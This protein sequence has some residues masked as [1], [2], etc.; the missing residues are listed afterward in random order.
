MT[1]GEFA[2][3][4]L[5]EYAVI[6]DGQRGA[7]I[8]PRG[9]I[10][11]L[12]MPQWHGDAVFA[13]L[14]GGAGCYAVT[15]TDRHVWGG[16]YQPGTLIWN[17]RW[18]TSDGVVEC[19]E[20]LAYPGR[21]G[22]AVLLRR[23]TAVDGDARMRV[24]L[25]PR[26]DYGK[27]PSDR[28]R[29]ESGEWLGVAG[30]TPWGWSGAPD[31]RPDADGRLVAELTV[32]AG[33]RHDLV[34]AIGTDEPLPA[35]ATCWPETE[36]A[37]RAAVGDLDIVAADDARHSLAV[38]RGL[39]ST[40]GGMV[41]AMTTSM[42][43]RFEAGRNYDYRYVWIRDQAMAGQAAAAAGAY[44]M[45]DDTVRFLTARL[46]AD[47][48][49][50]SPAYT[51]GGERIPD[52]RELD[53]PGYP[54]G[55]DIVGNQVR[56]QFQLDAFGEALLVLAAAGRADRIGHDARRA[57]LIAARAI[58][59]RWQQPDAGIWELDQRNWTHSRLICAAGL[60]TAATAPAVGLDADRWTRL[61]DTLV[62]DTDRWARHPAGYWQR[63]DNDPG[64]DAALLLAGLRG[65]VPADDPRTVATVREYVRALTVDGYAYR[66]RH[67]D[68][69]LGEAEGAFLL[70]GFLLAMACQ[71]QGH[72]LAA[73]RWFERHR[74]ACGPAGLLSEEYDVKQRQLRGNLPQAFVHAA[75]LESATRL[76]P[77]AD[78]PLG[79][80]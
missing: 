56:H 52:Q 64:L 39:T 2:P 59:Q 77:A 61:A 69:K 20:A 34:F 37:W 47:G 24:V 33:H 31:A 28:L 80:G 6:A 45:L 35:P 44:P 76:T 25:D 43:E 73:A 11:W 15:P 5:R 21:E 62:A 75:L 12:C 23:I 68:R 58:E 78:D 26:S 38:L 40:S 13:T 63:A 27:R 29:R 55:Y 60:R 54:G 30:E 41:A 49:R 22:R 66:F 14:I 4:V 65:A 57:A 50:L 36:K 17:S 3:H 67:D 42:P 10:C 8:G 74:A 53:L 51:V 16:Y 79:P 19:R 7:V 70:C 72:P 9:D 18:V 46:V 71:Q 1:D 32:P 48:P